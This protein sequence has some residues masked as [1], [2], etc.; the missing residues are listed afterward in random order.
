MLLV[1]RKHIGESDFEVVAYRG[2]I[3]MLLRGKS[4]VAKAIESIS[5]YKSVAFAVC[6]K[7]MKRYNIQADQLLPRI[8]VVPDAIMEIVSKQGDGWGYIKKSH[9]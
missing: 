3:S 7:T 5:L 9:H 4:A 6:P 8:I 2:A 1:C